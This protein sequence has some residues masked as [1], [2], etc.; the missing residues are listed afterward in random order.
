MLDDEDVLKDAKHR[1]KHGRLP[2]EP[3]CFCTCC[4]TVWAS[5]ACIII[6]LHTILFGIVCII[7]HDDQ[8][9]D[10]KVWR[11]LLDKLLYL[12]TGNAAYIIGALVIVVSLYAIYV[13]FRVACTPDEASYRSAYRVS[14]FLAVMM[15]IVGVICMF[16]VGQSDAMDKKAKAGLNM[17][18]FFG[19]GVLQ[20]LFA[21]T[22]EAHAKYLA[23][24]NVLRKDYQWSPFF[25]YDT[26]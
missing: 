1:N 11:E 5:I 24:A 25:F 2:P 21:S 18:V 23:A 16:L 12:Q 14:L 10:L 22:Y 7:F 15:M 13:N 20:V 8:N 26:K 19:A 3:T 17:L 4:G 9:T 6:Y